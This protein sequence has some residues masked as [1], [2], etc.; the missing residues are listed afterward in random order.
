MTPSGY[1]T[2]LDSNIE[3]TFDDLMDETAT[4]GA[5]KISPSVSGAKSWSGSKLIFN[6]S[7]ALAEAKTYTVTI[8]D[9]K[10]KDLAGNHLSAPYEFSFTT[11]VF[12]SSVSITAPKAGTYYTGDKLTIQAKVTGSGSALVVGASVAATGV[13]SAT[14][15]S[16]T[17][18]VYEGSCVLS[19]STTGTAR[20][21]VTATKVKT[22]SAYVSLTL[23]AAA[24]LTMD[25][26]SPTKFDYTRGDTIPVKV[27][28]K[29][30]TTAIKDASVSA[31]SLT[32]KNNND[33]TYSANLTTD[34][35]TLLNTTVII[36][37]NALVTNKTMFATKTLS[38]NLKPATLKVGV[39]ILGQSTKKTSLAGGDSVS[40]RAN[41]SYRDGTPADV[42]M[43]GTLTVGRTTGPQELIP[44]SFM[45]SGD[46]YVTDEGVYKVGNIDTSFEGSAYAFD[47]YNNTGQSTITARGPAL[48]LRFD[49][50]EPKE[51]QF[52]PGQSV[53]I[54][55]KVW[56]ELNSTYVTNAV[57]TLGDVA[58]ENSAGSYSTTYE[59]PAGFTNGQLSLTVKMVAGDV[60]SFYDFPIAVSHGLTVDFGATGRDKRISR[61]DISFN[62]EY[63]N[64]DPVTE[65]NFT[66]TVI[67]P[68]GSTDYPLKLK[69]AAW[70]ASVNLG[71]EEVSGIE[72]V[73]SGS[74][75]AGN[76]VNAT[77]S[78]VVY[79]AEK[80]PEEWMTKYWY[81]IVGAIVL[82]AAAFVAKFALTQ[83]A[84]SRRLQ[85]A[86]LIEYKEAWKE[87]E[88]LAWKI[89]SMGVFVM[90]RKY[91]KEM[92]D[93][94]SQQFAQREATL[95][96]KLSQ[97]ET[98]SDVRKEKG[99]LID[100]AQK[101]LEKEKPI[102]EARVVEEIKIYR[103]IKD[104]AKAMEYGT[105][106]DEIVQSIYKEYGDELA[107][108]IIR[109]A[110]LQG[111][112]PAESP[113]S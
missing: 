17:P 8:N 47:A 105:K 48:G 9:T 69:G 68:K 73:L 92:L 6:P 100:Q 10:A 85:L 66:L 106:P 63:P 84:H 18:G 61:G 40:L 54:V 20:L 74:D 53:R 93:G 82:I 98:D 13:C 90:A 70:S 97:L 45:R 34:Y 27:S 86:K 5:F 42:T 29:S 81:L 16:S 102:W 96:A 77:L 44:L 110:R 28:V 37:A 72:F 107:E 15:S 95:L 109:D 41:A 103:G 67:S 101:E 59:I 89:K 62:I 108:K 21:T 91:P 33:G 38:F 35:K 46:Y 111:Y 56:S 3:I 75:V 24:V 104:I 57:V 58:F 14:L 51:A 64:G 30:G 71:A 60:T 99:K 112:L 55:G 23:K 11:D 32:F 87:R 2:S 94:L 50:S 43:N 36:N 25:V 83:A 7:S 113:K 49:L 80:T 52:A 19:N 65:G 78:N 76:S 22:A 31:P 1:G 26:V 12:P 4:S 39:D 79:S 88:R